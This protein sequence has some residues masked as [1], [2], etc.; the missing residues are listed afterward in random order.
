M[1][2]EPSR[3]EVLGAACVL[4]AGAG[5]G[6]SGPAWAGALGG[7]RASA[8]RGAR[9]RVLRV[10]H[11]T[12]V[13]VQPE[14][15][16]GEGLAACLRHVQGQSDP[17]ALILAGGDNIMDGFEQ[18]EARTRTLFEQWR[19]VLRAECSLEVRPAV[20]N[21][22]IWGWNKRKSRTTGAEARWGKR[23]AVEALEIPER[24]YW[25][26]R[27]GW[28][29][30]VLD[31]THPDP[32][33]PDGYIA[34][35]DEAQRDWFERELAAT[36]GTTPV[37]VLTHIPILTAT[38]ILGKPDEKTGN[39]VG[40]GSLMHRDSPA[41][42]AAFKRHG[43]VRLAL[44]GHMHRIDRVDYDGT[45]YLCNGAV[46]GSWWK[47]PHHECREG[48]ALIDLFDDGSFEHRYETFGWQAQE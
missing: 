34:Q 18:D 9:R 26:D 6:L 29:F 12:D 37:L 14:R 45:T 44:S 48:Y 17:P 36:P 28:R 35:L 7:G 13:H 40:S 30:F 24:H 39:F 10:A 43:N 27:A 25:F 33:D 31:S 38:V 21:H 19:G 15:R 2:G 1:R 8:S 42:R 11:L 20:G 46:S 32:G 41:I 3:R 4:A 47:G 16:A 23:W 5:L 22:D